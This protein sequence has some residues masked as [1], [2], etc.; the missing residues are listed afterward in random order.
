MTNDPRDAEVDA[1]RERMREMGR[2]SRE[3]RERAPG[4]APSA[5]EQGQRQRGFISDRQQGRR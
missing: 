5:P 4:E 3:I 1:L 2:K